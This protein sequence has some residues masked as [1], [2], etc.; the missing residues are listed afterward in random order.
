MLNGD[1]YSIE[2]DIIAALNPSHIVRPLSMDGVIIIWRQIDVSYT[3]GVWMQ[4][5]EFATVY[6]R[7]Y[8][9]KY[10]TAPNQSHRCKQNELKSDLYYSYCIPVYN[11][12]VFIEKDRIAKNL[13]E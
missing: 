10:C 1:I 13:P 5:L 2:N 6:L 3:N 7:I 11:L 8:C 9:R 12:P 4:C